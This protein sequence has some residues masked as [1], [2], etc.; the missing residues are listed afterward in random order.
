M[1]FRK[2]LKKGEQ[3]KKRIFYRNVMIPPFFLHFS[4]VDSYKSLKWHERLNGICGKDIYMKT[5]KTV[6]LVFWLWGITFAQ[7]TVGDP[8]PNFVLPDTAGV[9]INLQQFAGKVI[10]LNFF[11]TWCGPC[12]A[13]APFLQDTIWNQYKNMDFVLLG[14]DYRETSGAV[15][16]FIGNYGITYPMVLDSDGKVFDAYK[17]RGFPTSVFIDNQGRIAYVE[18]GYDIEQF[19][20]VIDSLLAVTAISPSGGGNAQTPEN[21]RLLSAYPNPF[22]SQVRI[23]IQLKQRAKVAVQLFNLTGKMVLSRHLALSA[24]E[25]RIPIHL[26]NQASG[27]YFLRL[28]NGTQAVYQKLLLQK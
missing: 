10:Q 19:E 1:R 5:A 15:K 13:E 2:K 12:N 16:N 27:V 8:A 22:N 20:Q 21:L 6:V 7:P 4:A 11:A 28:Q 24:G 14:V 17:I 25:H 9:N 23:A 18:E 3:H 26:N